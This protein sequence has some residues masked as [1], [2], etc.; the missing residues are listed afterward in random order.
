MNDIRQNTPDN[1]RPASDPSHHHQ[2]LY[3]GF[4]PQ[5]RTQEVADG[6]FATIHPDGSWGLSNAG[7]VHSSGTVA[8]VD[9]LLTEDRTR[10]F[11]DQIRARTGTYAR[12]VINTHHHHDH[13]FG[14]YLFPEAV[15]V[16]HEECREEVLA[17]GLSPADRDPFVPWGD[18]EVRP[19]EI[20]F[21][22]RLA[23]H[24]G[25]AEAQLIHVGPAHT[26]NDVVVWLPESRVLF[27]G[28]AL[29]TE[30]TPITTD[31]SVSG[32]L[33]ALD[34][35]RSLDPVVVVPGHGELTDVGAIDAW[36]GYFEFLQKAAAQAA[37]AGV[38]ALE[39][40][41]GLDLGAYGEWQHPER[42]VL[43]LHRAMAE[44]A[45]AHPGQK[46]DSRAIWA[47]MIAFDPNAYGHKLVEGVEDYVDHD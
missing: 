13:T 40:S 15:V 30:A 41:R 2:G 33:R 22:D 5:P 4:V 17:E 7:F 42:I 11:I 46:L 21:R 37:N 26:R 43:N 14:N 10:R 8:V 1:A 25:N 39:A 36:R 24:V 12:F 32:S 3:R 6:V 31:G 35:M 47:D 28:D 38:S 23:V 44:N 16:G 20:T 18:I 19:P 29:F 27:A 45:G 9:S 34:L